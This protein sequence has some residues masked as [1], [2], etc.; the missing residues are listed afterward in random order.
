MGPRFDVS[1]SIR[2]STA[3]ADAGRRTGRIVDMGRREIATKL[4]RE[5]AILS[6]RSPRNDY[7]AVRRR[8]RTRSDHVGKFAD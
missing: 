3:R 1:P 8:R 5:V 2:R 4:R 7:C 6:V